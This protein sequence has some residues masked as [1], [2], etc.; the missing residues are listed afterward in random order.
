MQLHG[1]FEVQQQW[2]RWEHNASLTSLG[3][4]EEALV[5]FVQALPSVIVPAVSPP[6]ILLLLF[7]PPKIDEQLPLH[8][9]LAS[10]SSLI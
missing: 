4:L 6:I 2:G 1:K 9:S 5:I 7:V 8:L 10:C 3:H